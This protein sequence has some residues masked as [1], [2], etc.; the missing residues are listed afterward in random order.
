M[1][2][3]VKVKGRNRSLDCG[4]WGLN[5]ESALKSGR[6]LRGNQLG[7]LVVLLLAIQVK[8]EG[9]GCLETRG[10]WL[11]VQLNSSR[12]IDE[13][14]R[15][16][17]LTNIRVLIFVL[18]TEVNTSSYLHK[19]LRL[20]LIKVDIHSESILRLESGIVALLFPH[21][22]RLGCTEWHVLKIVYCL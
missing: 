22:L 21:S 17:G 16:I 7:V 12:L 15:L 11:Q 2:C 20:T 13:S 18:S 5:C 4:F 8:F 19:I 1:V 6:C 14:K 10:W 3:E 9:H